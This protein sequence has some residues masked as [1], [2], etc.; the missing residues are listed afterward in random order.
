M[1]AI[2]GWNG[3]MPTGLLFQLLLAAEHRGRDSTGIAYW[4]ETAQQNYLVKHAVTAALFTKINGEYITEAQRSVRGIAHTRRASPKMP[5][6]NDNAHPFMYES[7]VY[8]HNGAIKNWKELREATIAKLEK[9]V[10]TDP[11]L[12]L[13]LQYIKK[14]T[15]DSMI[16][17]PAIEALNFTP[18]VG[19]MGLVWLYANQ[20]F[21]FHSKK[22]L[23]A[24]NIVW[25]YEDSKEINSLTISASTWEIIDVALHKTKNIK[26]DA[27]ESILKENTLYELKVGQVVDAGPVP[28]N[29]ANEV[30][31]FSSK[32]DGVTEPCNL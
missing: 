1:C 6:N 5:I 26:F 11:T 3:K 20:V 27:E 22:E 15:T 31:Q 2:I 18:A 30:D 32:V 10:Q 25:N 24:A 21:A 29:K 23:T 19:A 9:E 12:E 13:K 7:W 28:V 14:I 8:A 17:G 16:L 4:D